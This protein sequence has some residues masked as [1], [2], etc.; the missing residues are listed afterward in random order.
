[1][2][3]LMSFAKDWLGWKKAMV[4]APDVEAEFL[5]YLDNLVVG[6]LKVVDSTWQFTYSDEFKLKTDL[7][8]IVEFP[9]L[10]QVYENDELWQFFASRIPSM[11][12]PDVERAMLKDEIEDDDVIALLRRFG[13]RTITNPFELRYHEANV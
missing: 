13:K 8:P 4:V 9:D 12:Q 5:L 10:D 3:M 1:M 11:E 2:K 6:T 7:R